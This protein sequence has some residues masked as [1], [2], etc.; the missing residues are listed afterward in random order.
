MGKK[1]AKVNSTRDLMNFEA[2]KPFIRSCLINESNLRKR[3]VRT[4]VCADVWKTYFVEL[5]S[6][7]DRRTVCYIGDELLS[8]WNKAVDDLDQAAEK[9][10]QGSAT[11]VNMAELL[12]NLGGSVK[13]Y[14][15]TNLEGRS[16]PGGICHSA[17][18]GS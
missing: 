9:N 13:M 2:A 6:Q 7:K 14:M 12:G 3:Q 16:V 17:V 4:F 1:T 11:I 8:R 10:E 15:A 5:P 18:F